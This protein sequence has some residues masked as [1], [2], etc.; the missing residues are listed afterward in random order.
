MDNAHIDPFDDP[1]ISWAAEA[2]EVPNEPAIAERVAAGIEVG[3]HHDGRILPFPDE[4]QGNDI[5]D[6]LTGDELG[7]VNTFR[8]SGFRPTIYDGCRDEEGRLLQAVIRFDHATERKRVLPLRYCGRGKL[9]Q[10]VFWFTWI[11]GTKPLYGL[12]QLAA[13]PEKPVLV[14]EG[15]KTCEAARKLFP[16]FVCITWLSGT[17]GVKRADLSPLKG[18]Q[19]A[20]WPDNDPP[21]RKAAR[22][23]AARA[24]EA[25]AA[26]ACIVDVPSE[27]VSGWDLAD[28]YPQTIAQ[29]HPLQQLVAT[30]RP[31]NPVIAASLLTSPVKGAIQRRLLGHKPGFSKVKH[32]DAANALSILDPDLPGHEWRA[33]ARAIYQAFANGGLAMFDSWSRQGDKY[34]EGEPAR[35]WDAY[36]SEEGFRGPSLAWLLAKAHHTAQEKQLNVRVA[37]AAYMTACIEELN[38]N[39]AVVSRGGKTVVVR[40]HFDPRT[41]SFAVSYLKKG[42]FIDTFVRPVPVGNEKYQPQGKLWFGSTKRRQYEGIY[43]APQQDVGRR[44]LNLW[45]GFTVQPSHNPEGWSKLKHHLLAH[46]AQ[47]DEAAYNYILDWLAFGVQRL[48]RPTGSALVF[49]GPKGAG[50]SIIIE[51]FGYL[52]GSHTFVTSIPDDIVGK[53][54]AH[55]ES[56]LL[57][58][59]E[60]AFAPQNRAADGTLKDLI[61]RRTLR[62]EDKFF[63][64][65]SAPS[66]LR[67]IMTSNNDQV[68]RADPGDRRYAVF[69]VSTPFQSDPDARRRYFGEMMEQME[70]SGYSALL[71]ELLARD[72]SCWNPEAIPQTAALREQVILNL[73]NDPVMAWYHA[74]LEDGIEILTGEGETL[75]YSWSETDVVW[76]PVKDTVADF[77]AFTK[78]HGQRCSDQRL[79]NKLAKFMPPDFRSVTRREVDVNGGTP[80]RMYPFPPLPEARERFSAATG[81]SFD[82]PP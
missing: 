82:K 40:E 42:D 62:L 59:V 75:I 23:F 74:R 39:H 22:L 30:S 28:D 5:L 21:G 13:N 29:E 14:S 7:T 47:G 33:V 11:P 12:D 37:E 49:K 8:A 65:W 35:L 58:G 50:K 43:F 45:R 10:R 6:A 73:P 9:G 46:V 61:T 77:S 31:I 52:F 64:V 55:L 70:T 76:V 38:E 1:L 72:I 68:V 24:I 26:S 51:I 36:A 2:D 16:D 32:E 71:G 63:S 34:K 19:V 44:N 15:E 17:P 78:R 56:T 4:L 18:R 27:L 80:V 20:I 53:F 3:N 25:G 60:E 79:K 57:F 66:H 41:D 69:E 48:D 81:F 54:N 67:I